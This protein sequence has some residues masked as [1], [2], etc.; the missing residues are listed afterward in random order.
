MRMAW[1]QRRWGANPA[2]QAKPAYRK[3][4]LAKAGWLLTAVDLPA[5]TLRRAFSG[6]DGEEGKLA[7]FA[8]LDIGRLFFHL[9]VVRQ[10]TLYCVCC[11]PAGR[12]FR[13]PGKQS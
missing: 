13:P 3:Y 10:R 2:P 6:S 7:T 1:L 5:F 4:A 8:V 11:F 12:R 9:I